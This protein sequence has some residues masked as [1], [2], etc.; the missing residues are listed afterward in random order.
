MIQDGAVVDAKIADGAV[1]ME[2]I[3]EERGQ[4][5]ETLDEFALG[6]TRLGGGAGLRVSLR[7][8]QRI[9]IRLDVAYGDKLQFYLQVLEAI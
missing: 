4:V 3:E 6:R 7:P 9:N 1:T 5:A 8:D 2:K